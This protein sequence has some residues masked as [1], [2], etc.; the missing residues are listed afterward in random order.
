MKDA[1][2]KSDVGEAELFALLR[3]YIG[4]VTTAVV[5]QILIHNFSLVLQGLLAGLACGHCI[6]AFVFAEPVGFSI[7]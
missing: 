4:G 3:Q 6:F 2:R 1:R 7:P 5:V